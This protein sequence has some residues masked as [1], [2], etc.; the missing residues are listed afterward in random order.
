M[1]DTLVLKNPL[2]LVCRCTGYRPILCGMKTFSS[3]GNKKELKNT[4][5]IVIDPSFSYSR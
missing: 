5:P 3:C 4:P 1:I 2:P